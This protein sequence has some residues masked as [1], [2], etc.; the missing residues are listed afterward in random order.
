MGKIVNRF[1]ILIQIEDVKL[2]WLEKQSGIGKKRW[3]NV[4]S[5]HLEMRA[6]EVEALAQIWPE[7]AYWVATGKELPSCGQISPL[8]KAAKES[9]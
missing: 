7:Y 8:T 3:A 5:G 9:S 2:P 6:A 1:K 4:K